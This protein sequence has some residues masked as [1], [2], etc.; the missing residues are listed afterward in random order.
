MRV[1]PALGAAA[2][3]LAL[4]GEAP[5]AV[6]TIDFTEPEFPGSLIDASN[7]YAAY[8]VL[9]SNAYFYADPL[10]PFD[11]QGVSNG[12]VANQTDPAQAGRIDFV[13]GTTDFFAFDW[14]TIFYTTN[15][16]AYDSS[17]NLVDS[18]VGGVGSGSNLLTGPGIAYV[19]W[20]DNGG[21]VQLSTISYDLTAPIPLPATLPLLLGALGLGGLAARR[22][23]SGA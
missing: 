5:A 15:V 14:W 19:T 23:K 12:D 1:L 2:L 20:S 16:S 6:T 22:S 13:G 9:F 18:F 21:F 8:G 17:D 11:G 7:Q 10:G 3:G 4:A